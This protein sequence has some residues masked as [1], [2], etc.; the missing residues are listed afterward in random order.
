MPASSGS[1]TLIEI[2]RAADQIAERD[3]AGAGDRERD[4]QLGQRHPQIGP[5]L[6]GAR[7]RPSAR[8]RH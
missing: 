4:R 8:A 6:A 5:E 7:A 2:G 3:A 1:N